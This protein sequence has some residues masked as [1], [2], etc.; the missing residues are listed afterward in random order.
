MR[1]VRTTGRPRGSARALP[2]LALVEQVRRALRSADRALTSRLRIAL[3]RE[4]LPFGR[5][6]VL[7]L[8]IARGPTT[9]KE[10]AAALGVTTANMPALIDR[11]EADRL[12]TRTRNRKDRRE[13]L[14]AAT[15]R[16]RDRFRRLRDTAG[17]ELAGAFRGWSVAELRALREALQRV[18]R[19]PEAQGLVQ[20][21][22]LR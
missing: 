7:R 21:R 9:S 1:R 8:L 2:E 12:V 22:V 17:E 13:I 18:S 10:L 15:A 11:L 16:G 4:G 6:V 3:A 5:F 20:L 14:V 19:C